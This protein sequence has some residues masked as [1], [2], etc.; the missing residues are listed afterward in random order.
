[1]LMHVDDLLIV[2]SRNFIGH[3]VAPTLLEKYK[4]S[5][6][7]L[8][9]P[10]D[11]LEFLK[12]FELVGVKKIWRP[13]KCTRSRNGQRFW[14]DRR[15]WCRQ[16]HQVQIWRWHFALSCTWP[17]RVSVCYPWT[18]ARYMSKP[19]ER[20]WDILKYLVQY[21]LGRVEYGLLMKL[22]ENDTSNDVDLLV[23]SDS[24]WAGHK[25]PRKSA[26]S[27]FV[28]VDGLLLHSSSRRQGIIALSSGEAECYPS[29]SSSCDGIYLSRCLSLC[30][31]LEVKIKLLIDSSSARQILSRSG[32]GRIRPP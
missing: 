22:E 11:E 25:G 20:A 15:A 6:E 32:V 10:G 13:K 7:I 23:Y 16:G 1:M 9:I 27:C 26:S 24:D 29:V 30:S 14:R 19:T 12:L 2:G 28:K 8:Q 4:V 18:C 5:L 3:E 21:L 31:G 17:H